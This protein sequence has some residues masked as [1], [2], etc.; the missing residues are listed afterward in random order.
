MYA[1]VIDAAGEYSI[2]MEV[3]RVADEYTIAR[4]EAVAPIP[5]RTSPYDVRVDFPRV[6]FDRPGQYEFRLFANSRFVGAAVLLVEASERG[7]A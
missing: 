7:A 2:G 5:D 1:R 3:V 6:P 4:G